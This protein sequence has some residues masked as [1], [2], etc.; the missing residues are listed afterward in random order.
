MIGSA[1]S[2]QLAGLLGGMVSGMARKLVI[3][4]PDGTRQLLAEVLADD[5]RQLQERLKLHP[6]LL[7]LE[8]LGLVGPAV[9]VGR[10]SAIMAELV[11]PPTVTCTGPV[12]VEPGPEWAARYF[13][14]QRDA[15]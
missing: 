10:E 13:D 2:L 7:P 6:E 3:D 5:E 8:E 15:A 9:V 11:D 12:A 14:L 4:L 1:V